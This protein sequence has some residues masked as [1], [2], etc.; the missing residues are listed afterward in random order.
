MSP[1]PEEPFLNA[2]RSCAFSIENKA[3]IFWKACALGYK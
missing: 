1:K 3:P 2:Q